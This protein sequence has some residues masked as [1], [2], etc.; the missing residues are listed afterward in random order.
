MCAVAAQTGEPVW[1]TLRALS[2]SWSAP[3]GTVVHVCENPT[4]AE[5]AADRFGAACPPLV[6][7]DGMPTTTAVDLVRGLA[8][9]GCVVRLRADVDGSGF[10]IV[11]TLLA[12]VRP[13]R[14]SLWRYDT[15]SYGRVR[16]ED[17]V[18]L[19]AAPSVEPN[20]MVDELAA[21]F[22]ASGQP[23]HEE[24][25]LEDLLADLATLVG[26]APEVDRHARRS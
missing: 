5:A 24:H 17:A 23:L 3:A 14:A 25:L 11:R 22:M 7:T 8:E 19:P 13:G 20:V 21:A 10:A 2:G 16:G 12:A 18:L 1:L 6:C 26:A 9:A 15:A 4:V